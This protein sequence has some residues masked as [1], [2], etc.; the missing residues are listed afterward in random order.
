MLLEAKYDTVEKLASAD[1]NERYELVKQLNEIRKFYKAHI[2]L[3]DMLL[4][5]EAAKV[6]SLEIVLSLLI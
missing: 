2:G 4:C 3:H 1:Y 6:V 5:V